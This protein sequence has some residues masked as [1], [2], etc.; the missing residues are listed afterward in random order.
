MTNPWKL[1]LPAFLLGALAG[2]FVGVRAQRRAFSRM[3]QKGM[4]VEASLKR[5]TARLSLDSEQQTAVRPILQARRDKISALHDETRT[6]FLAIRG[7]TKDAMDKVLRPEQRAT[8][9]A[10]AAKADARF[11]GL[12]KDEPR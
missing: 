1:V 2:T 11:K 8:Y 4:D 6:R 10:M 7:E 5:L 9:D 12:L 3:W